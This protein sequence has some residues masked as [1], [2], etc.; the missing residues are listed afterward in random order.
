MIK[1]EKS[2]CNLKERSCK[3]ETKLPRAKFTKTGENSKNSTSKRECMAKLS[4]KK[5]VVRMNIL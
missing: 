4:Q 3:K 1:E 5:N 2:K